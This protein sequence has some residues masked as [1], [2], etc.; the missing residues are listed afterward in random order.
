MNVYL[1]LC[2]GDVPEMRALSINNLYYRASISG[3]CNMDSLGSRL[4]G[5]HPQ[6]V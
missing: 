4:V 1:G 2:R 6:G 3:K 5:I